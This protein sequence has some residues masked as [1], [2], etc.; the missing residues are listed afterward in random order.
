[1]KVTGEVYKLIKR[2]MV[3]RTQTRIRG[4]MC[5]VTE[6]LEWMDLS[7][8]QYKYLLYSSARRQVHSLN[9]RAI[10]Q[11]RWWTSSLVAA[12]TAACKTESS[13][14]SKGELGGQMHS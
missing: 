12:N 13:R 6:E 3:S 1:M 10:V 2:T 8:S 11:A 4:V 9:C 14:T 5:T 7:L